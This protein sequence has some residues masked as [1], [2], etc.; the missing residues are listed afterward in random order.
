MTSGFQ[1]TATAHGRMSAA[2][3]E[4]A[5]VATLRGPMPGGPEHGKVARWTAGRVAQVAGLT[6]GDA[7]EAIRRMR[8]RGQID[9]VE[10]K[11]SKSMA[12]LAASHELAADE[13]APHE[14]AVDDGGLIPPAVANTVGAAG[15]ASPPVPPAA[16]GSPTGAQL[17]A[18]IRIEAARRGVSLNAFLAP[19]TGNQAR[20]LAQLEA[21]KLPLAR[22]V[23]RVEALIAHGAIAPLPNG[24]SKWIDASPLLADLAEA[25]TS[26]RRAA[27]KI[28]LARPM[29][30]AVAPMPGCTMRG[31]EVLIAGPMWA[32]VVALAERTGERAIT[33][34]DRVLA[35][36]L[37][38]VAEDANEEAFGSGCERM[39]T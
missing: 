37:L 12:A 1:R 5:V 29:L 35:A 9:W 13:L 11:L 3:A 32:R 30:A 10:V 7:G 25:E 34:F 33:V 8:M 27:S 14:Q 36:G 24:R 26:A 39:R 6:I 20:W 18:A 2:A 21:A 4:A 38:C 23:E 22:T 31:R 28:A 17:G 15:G 19:L 16:T